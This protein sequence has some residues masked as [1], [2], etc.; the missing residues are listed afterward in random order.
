MTPTEV[1]FAFVDAINEKDME[2]LSDLMTANHKFI[3]GDGSEHVGKDQMK[4]GW[5]EHLK[6]IPDLTLTVSSHFEEN[7]TVVL[8]G[9]S[10]GTIIQNGELSPENSWGVPSAWRVRVEA[11]KVAE[12]QLFANQCAL[13]VIYDRIITNNS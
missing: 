6:L 3:D 4:E 9:Q 13:H 8:I 2:R 5:S 1:A 7:D 12:W 11:E 10:K